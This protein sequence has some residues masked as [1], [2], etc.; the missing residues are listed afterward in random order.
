MPALF[1]D[2]QSVSENLV[3][4]EASI[5]QFADIVDVGGEPGDAELPAPTLAIAR[6]GVVRQI[7]LANFLRFYRLGQELVWQWMWDRITAVATDRTQ[8]AVA[9]RLVTSWMFGYIDAA[10]TARSRPMRPNV[11]SGCA[12]RPPPAPTRSLT[13]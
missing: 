7:P 8:Q 2:P 1:T 3:S 5:R 13:S 10:L 11:K 6:A 4:T 9:L 12:T